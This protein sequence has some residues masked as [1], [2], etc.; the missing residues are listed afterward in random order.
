MANNSIIQHMMNVLD[1]YEAGTLP[2]GQVAAFFEQYAQFLEGI[3]SQALSSVLQGA[4][5]LMKSDQESAAAVSAAAALEHLRA[6]VRSLLNE[7]TNADIIVK[8]PNP[9]S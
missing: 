4:A 7:S 9:G 1:R 5:Q 3:S 2:A 8:P 6:Q